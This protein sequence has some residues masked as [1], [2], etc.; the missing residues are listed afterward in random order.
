MKWIGL[1]GGIAT[2]KST[3][4]NMLRQA[5]HTVIDADAVAHEALV[6]SSPVLPQ[7]ISAFGQDLLDK[8][9]NV[10]RPLLGQ[11]IFKNKSQR[12]LLEA[13]THPFVRERVAKLRAEAE[14]RGDKVAF[15]DVPLLYEKNMQEDFDRVVVV[16]CNADLQLS[17]LMTRNSLSQTE[18]QERLAAQWPM[19]E[20][21]KRA[22]ILIHNNGSFVDLQKQVDQ[23]T[24]KI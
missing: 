2:G 19:V 9:G 1:T 20:K 5:G 17:R 3:V 23:L 15:Y 4:A 8:Q 14:A 21:E 16:T 12:L 22:D 7:I 6:A 13:I 11:K 24:A 10:Q 18:A